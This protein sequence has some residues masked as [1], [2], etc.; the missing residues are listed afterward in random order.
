M[1]ERVTYIPDLAPY[2]YHPGAPDAVAIGWLDWSMPFTTGACPPGVQD[3]LVSLG[4]RP[5]RLM[6]G[7]HYC[8]FCLA[9]V[10]PQHVIRADVRLYKAPD[11]ACGNG[12][13]WLTGVD[14]TNFAAPALIGHYVEEHHYLPPDGF[15]E[16][17]RTGVP[18]PGVE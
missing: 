2:D 5:V 8:Q 18:T 10:E 15:I 11:V 17:V 12:E 13:I 3:R 4:V 6:R 7:Y 16:A 1:I 14:G 9:A